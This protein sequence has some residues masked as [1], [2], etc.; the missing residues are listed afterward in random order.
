MNNKLLKL[1]EEFISSLKNIEKEW[2][3]AV[4][5]LQFPPFTTMGYKML[6]NFWNGKQEIN[7]LPKK[8]EKFSDIFYSFWYETKDKY[9]EIVFK[10]KKD[11]YENATIEARFNQEV[12]DNFQNNL[13]K[14]KRGKTI[15]WWKNEKYKR[16][17]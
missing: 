8:G 11:D 17:D 6:P 3:N 1:N 12:E 4:I 7:I 14:S 13:P 15:P 10:T 16:S 9:N 5:Y 2:D